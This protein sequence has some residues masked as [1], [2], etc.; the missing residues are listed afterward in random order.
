LSEK[1]KKTEEK[2]MKLK[3]FLSAIIA[4]AMIFVLSV[5]VAGMG[6]PDSAFEFTPWDVDDDYIPPAWGGHLE[7][8]VSEPPPTPSPVSEPV[9]IVSEAVGSQSGSSG[10]SNT[11]GAGSTAEPDRNVK[12]GVTA[13]SGLIIMAILAGG[14]AVITRKKRG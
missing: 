5:S 2:L 6:W 3:K 12:A 10:V 7:A 11:G 14:T 1:I 4:G 9:E 13:S 8:E